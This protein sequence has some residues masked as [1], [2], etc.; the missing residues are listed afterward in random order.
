MA[1]A[2][3]ATSPF[4]DSDDMAARYDYRSYADLVSDTDAPVTEASLATDAKLAAALQDASGVIELACTVGNRYTP[5][6]LTQI[7]TTA[8]NSQ[9]VLKRL[10]CDLAMG[11]LFL[12]RPDRKGE[13]P[14][15]FRAALETLK[16]LRTGEY[17]FGILEN[18]NAG[19]LGIETETAQVVEDRDGIV[20]EAS[21]YFS[22]RNNR[23]HG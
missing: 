7:A 13:P 12:R 11:Y 3:S 9:G 14:A 1:Q 21:R 23:L 4:A 20:V 10:T 18:Q 5:A 19:N 8:N 15:A 16:S 6:V 17:V 2:S 22:T